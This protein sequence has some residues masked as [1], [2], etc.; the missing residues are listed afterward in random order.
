[1]PAKKTPEATPE[2]RF[3]PYTTHTGLLLYVQEE[4]DL[5][6]VWIV[7]DQIKELLKTP[8]KAAAIKYAESIKAHYEERKAA[9]T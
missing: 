3:Q 8:V 6:S 5:H 7:G 1:M 2:P 4:D 9:E